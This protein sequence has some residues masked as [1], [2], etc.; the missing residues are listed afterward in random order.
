MLRNFRRKSDVTHGPASDYDSFKIFR[1]EALLL[2]N[3]L[4]LQRSFTK[5]MP[6]AKVNL[7]C[8]IKNKTKSSNNFVA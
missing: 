7:F 3:N 1:K 4:H 5:L 2:L 8:L 6:K